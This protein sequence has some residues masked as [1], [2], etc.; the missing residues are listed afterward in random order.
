VRLR[1]RHP[2]PRVGLL[3]VTQPFH[4]E[5]IPDGGAWVVMRRTFLSDTDDVM[6]ITV[7]LV[8]AGSALDPRRT[9]E[10]VDRGR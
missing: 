1:R 3:D 2:A 4:V 10:E 7:E 6:V 5:E 8:R 9:A